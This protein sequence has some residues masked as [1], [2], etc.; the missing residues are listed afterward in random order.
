ME[1]AFVALGA[2]GALVGRQ[3]VIQLLGD[4]K[5][6]AHL[7]FGVARMHIATLDMDLCRGGVEVLELELPYLAAVHGIGIFGVEAGHV[8]LDHSPANLFV[9]SETNAHGAVLK[10]GMIHNI[11]HRVHDFS[12]TGFIVGAEQ[13]STVGGDD[14]LALMSQQFGEFG[15]LEAEARNTFQ[16]DVG[17]VVVLDYLGLDVFSGGVGGGVHMGDEADCGNFGSAGREIARDASH[18]IAVFVEGGL[19]AEVIQ[20]LAQELQKV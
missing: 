1:E 3:K 6:V 15:S 20:F 2:L 4:V 12:N 14:G 16:G 18:H 8:K 17:A 13:R 9:G 19:G 5:G 10:L 7:A 11:L